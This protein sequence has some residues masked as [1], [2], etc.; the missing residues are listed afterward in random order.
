MTG[1]PHLTGASDAQVLTYPGQAHFAVAGEARKCGD[2]TFWTPNGQ[3]GA[4][5]AICAKARAIGAPKKIPSFASACKYFE[6][7][8]A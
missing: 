2:C 6:A 5:T 1:L 4:T 8:G 7:R 3:K